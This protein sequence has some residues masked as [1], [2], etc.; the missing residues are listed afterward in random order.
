MRST[1]L[2]GVMPA[3]VAGIH[4]LRAEPKK[5]VEDKKDVDGRNKSGHDVRIAHGD[6]SARRLPTGVMPALVAGIHDLTASPKKDVDGRNES[7]H[8]DGLAAQR[9]NPP[10][11]IAG[12]RIGGLRFANPPL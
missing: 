3:L 7:G 8:D 4:A 1:L 5:D 11:C 9:R 12:H 10:S 2:Y 6:S